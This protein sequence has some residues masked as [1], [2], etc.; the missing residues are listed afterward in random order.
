[1]N[2]IRKSYILWGLRNKSIT[3]P[4]NPEEEWHVWSYEDEDVHCWNW[5][6]GASAATE[7][8]F[9]VCRQIS[10]HIERTEQSVNFMFGSE[11]T[12]VIKLFSQYVWLKLNYYY[13]VTVYT[14]SNKN[15]VAH[16]F[17]MELLS[18]RLN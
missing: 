6:T 12:I 17:K 9:T 4:L 7:L 18:S 10:H 15:N 2:N 13:W 5:C 8:Q 11:I 16:R 3:N 1:M 14:E